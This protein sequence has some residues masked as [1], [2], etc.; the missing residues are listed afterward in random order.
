M[1][2]IFLIYRKFRNSLKSNTTCLIALSYLVEDSRRNN[3][4][5]MDEICEYM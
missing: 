1:E 4:H 5:V 3:I 2:D